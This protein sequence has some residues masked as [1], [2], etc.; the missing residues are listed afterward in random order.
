MDPAQMYSPEHL[1]L[2]SVPG[3]HA[4]ACVFTCLHHFN[5]HPSEKWMRSCWKPQNKSQYPLSFSG[6][7]K[8]HALKVVCFQQSS[9]SH[10]IIP[11][12]LQRWGSPVRCSTPT[13]SS[14]ALKHLRSLNWRVNRRACLDLEYR[15]LCKTHSECVWS[16][17]HQHYSFIKC[18][19]DA[20]GGAC[21]R[22]TCD[23]SD[24]SMF[25]LKAVIWQAGSLLLANCQWHWLLACSLSL[26]VN[27]GHGLNM[28][29]AN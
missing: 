17:I 26:D 6:V 3:T 16:E 11:L 24:V 29:Y 21:L 15:L 19:K 22:R 13:V 20:S 12:V 18:V 9:V 10:P 27:T 1:S 7:L 25:V 28:P 23:R 14:I 4:C 5:H 2:L 8:T